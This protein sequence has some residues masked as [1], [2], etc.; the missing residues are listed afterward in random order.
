[1]ENE[2]AFYISQGV[3][4]VGKSVM[5][6][7]Y[8]FYRNGR[9]V[10][11]SSD[12][13]RR[14]YF[15]DLLGAAA[16]DPRSTQDLEAAWFDLQG[17][18]RAEGFAAAYL[19]Q[20]SLGGEPLMP[21]ITQT[22][23]DG[24]GLGNVTSDSTPASATVNLPNPATTDLVAGDQLLMAVRSQNGTGPDPFSIAGDHVSI[25]NYAATRQLAFIARKAPIVPE[26]PTA[27]PST[28]VTTRTLDNSSRTLYAPIFV[29]DVNLNII[30]SALATGSGG[31]TW[32]GPVTAASDNTLLLLIIGWE[33]TATNTPVYGPSVGIMA[34]AAQTVVGTTSTDA[35]VS[36]T[37]IAVY[38]KVVAKGD[39]LMADGNIN[40]LSGVGVGSS[41]TAELI[42][43]APRSIA[44]PKVAN[45]EAKAKEEQLMAWRGG[46]TVFPEHSEYAYHNAVGNGYI[47]L[48]ISMHRTTD[49]VWVANHDRYLDRTALGAETTTLDITAMTWADV[50]T[51]AIAF[52]NG[53]VPKPITSVQNLIDKFSNRAVFMVD[54]KNST[55]FL[56]DFLDMLDA[57]GGPE[58]FICKLS[59]PGSALTHR[60]TCAA[61]GYKVW[62]YY[63]AGED[64]TN[65]GLYDILGLNNSA[66]QVEWDTLKATGKP[67]LGHVIQTQGNYDE[68]L[69]KGADGFQVGLITTIHPE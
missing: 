26:D 9:A 55:A 37:G 68:A 42:A 31:I 17:Y 15:L 54:P 63:F 47:C 44:V 60:A 1:M 64:F 10:G 18:G 66:P 22:Y 49:D 29:R 39:Y 23:T 38:T 7:R 5:D 52:A 62:G 67:V 48:E 43:I 24:G 14:L 46:G 41:V 59:G 34:G 58:K 36:R 27:G 4:P 13:Y 3:I 11:L 16:N 19:G 33:M 57:N 65:A 2:L 21:L 51:H 32:T 61:R 12:D 53:R 6:G 28:I 56:S 69:A 35:G 8:E 50:Q 45:W 20:A 25:N 30:D 40:V